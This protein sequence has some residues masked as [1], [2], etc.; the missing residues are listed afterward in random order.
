MTYKTKFSIAFLF[1]SLCLFNGLFAQEKITEIYIVSSL[2][3][4]H[5]VNEKYTYDSLYQFIERVQPDVI[6]VE[7]RSEEIDSSDAYVSSMYP[8]E[9]YT[10]RNRFKHLP[11]F[12]IDWLGEEIEGKAV[13]EKYYETFFVITLQKQASQDSVMRKNLEILQPVRNEM[14]QIALKSSISELNDGRYD[15]LSHIYYLQL[16]HLYRDTPYQRLSEF[17]TQRD[18]QIAKNVIE[19]VKNHPGK[20]LLFVVGAD[21]RYFSKNYLLSELGDAIQIKT[22][23]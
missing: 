7:M 15:M 6:G 8:L 3:R 20:K 17:Y 12:G 13:P 14:N 4:A 19:V 11:V 18:E 22:I 5:Q 10:I 9:M 1:L 23:E 16:K 21:H 2:H